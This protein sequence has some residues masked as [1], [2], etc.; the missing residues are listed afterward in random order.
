MDRID[1]SLCLVADVEAAA[2]KYIISVIEQAVDGGVSLVQ[3]RTK[4]L[5]TNELFELSLK[6]R[7]ITKKKSIP[8]IIN[9]RVDIALSC[10][11]E[12]VH[13]GQDDLPV[14]SARK[15]L[16]KKKLI[17]VS[18]N[19]KKEAEEAEH[20]GADYLGVGPIFFTQTK[21]DIK[22]PLGVEGLREIRERVRIPILA[23]GGI[24]A[25]NAREMIEAGADGVA[26]V[27]AILATENIIKAARGLAQAIRQRG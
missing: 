27:S 10:D 20:R 24:N 8:L 12:G 3:L 16:G 17:G 2:G 13:L 6:A 18:V 22:P 14:S 11:A 26:V 9:D 4:K 7:E 21:K 1:W 25:E 19:T 15:I 5:K 23:I